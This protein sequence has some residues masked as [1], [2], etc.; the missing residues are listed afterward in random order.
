MS[1]PQEMIIHMKC[2]TYHCFSNTVCRY[3]EVNYLGIIASLLA[4]YFSYLT[5]DLQVQ[6]EL[7]YILL[8][9]QGEN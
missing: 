9:I 4:L 1:T 7:T 6:D 3:V 2:L 8:T 5:P